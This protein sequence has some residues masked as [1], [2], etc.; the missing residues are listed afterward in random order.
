MQPSVFSEPK[1][2]TVLSAFLADVIMADTTCVKPDPDMG[3]PSVEDDDLEDAGD[4]EFYD[5]SFMGTMYLARLPNYVWEAWSQ[6]E[7]DDEEI[8][9]GTIR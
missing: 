6:L 8:Q 3:S 5:S 9:I 2:Q 1:K 4:L 7:D